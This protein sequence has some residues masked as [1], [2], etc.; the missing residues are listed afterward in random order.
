VLAGNGWDDCATVASNMLSNLL[1]NYMWEFH[2]QTHDCTLWNAKTN[3]LKCFIR[4][5]VHFAISMSTFCVVELNQTVAILAQVEPNRS[6][7]GSS[8]C[9]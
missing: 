9:P 3:L 5:I 7:F 2:D 6:H 1:K 8:L 4:E